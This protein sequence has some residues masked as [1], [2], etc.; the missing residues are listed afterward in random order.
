MSSVVRLGVQETQNLS[1]RVLGYMCECPGVLQ[2]GQASAN[3]ILITDC[4]E[5]EVLGSIPC[6]K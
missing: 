4:S 2:P 6:T 3:I 5:E 1:L